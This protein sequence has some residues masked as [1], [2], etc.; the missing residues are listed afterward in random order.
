MTYSDLDRKRI[1]ERLKQAI[2]DGD[3]NR[4]AQLATDL[5]LACGAPDAALGK[6]A[7]V[8]FVKAAEVV[9]WEAGRK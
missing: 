6:M 1:N 5:A 3:I 8:A 7:I 9:I 2:R 4:A